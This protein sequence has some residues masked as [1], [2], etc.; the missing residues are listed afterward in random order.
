VGEFEKLVAQQ[1]FLKTPTLTGLGTG[2]H[3]TCLHDRP[4]FVTSDCASTHFHPPNY[5]LSAIIGPRDGWI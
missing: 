2:Q 3:Q 4:G 1:Y 5:L